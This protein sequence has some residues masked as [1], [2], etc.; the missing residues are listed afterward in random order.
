MTP[1]AARF[2]RR[3][4]ASVENLPTGFRVL[5]G[6]T[7]LALLADGLFTVGLAWDVLQRTGNPAALGAILACFS[8]TRAALLPLGGALADRHGPRRVLIAAALARA[9]LLPATGLA[10]I[11][12]QTWAVYPL[13]AALGVAS[14]AFYPADRS[15][16]PRVVPEAQLRRANGV[17][18]VCY[19]SGNIAGPAIAGALVALASG[20]AALVS[21]GA[22]YA[23]SAAA[24]GLLSVRAGTGGGGQ[25]GLRR[26]VAVGLRHVVREPK[27]RWLLACMAGVNLGFI[28]PF[29]VGLPA[30]V[31]Q[32]GDG[33]ANYGLLAAGFAAGSL[34]GGLAA[35]RI[36]TNR[37]GTLILA[38]VVGACLPFAAV[39]MIGTRPLVLALLALSGIGSG[40][41]NV[42]LI[43]ELQRSV[44]PAVL[45]RVM[46]LV[47]LASL[48]LA[49]L[50]QIAAG[51]LAQALGPAILFPVGAG[52]AL[53]VLLVAGPNL[54]RIT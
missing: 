41:A 54:R 16:L 38:S 18:H 1:R 49:P 30:L 53:V 14:A 35:G 12:G 13:A 31:S 32:A 24:L 45:G 10:L 6:S 2:P 17:M 46:S 20:G 26:S 47:M 48:G 4:G 22:C 28:G 52:F 40:L 39:G 50:S 9:V 11:L 3:G 7:L 33:A 34:A 29:T 5:A 44:D 51:T 23:F 21:A 43:T 36:T 8:V 37:G 25:T 19:E 42:V 15:L 27:L